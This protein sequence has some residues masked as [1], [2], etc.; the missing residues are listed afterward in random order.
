MSEQHKKTV[1]DFCQAWEN[2]DI[3]AVLGLM[4]SDAIYHNVPLEPLVGQAQI[5]AFLSAFLGAASAC[6]F[7]IL[8]VVADEQC[9]VTE[10]LDSFTLGDNTLSQLPV[11]GIFE[12][13][14]EGKISHW[15]E[16]F[17]LKTWADKGG[18]A[19]G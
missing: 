5:R 18:P 3:E 6:Q 4:S 17:D 11:L 8:T 16:Y 2:L 12:F 13:N 19:I 1:T 15:R 10:R 7:E 9:V 14:G